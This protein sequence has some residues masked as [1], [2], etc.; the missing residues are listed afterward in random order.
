MGANAGLSEFC[1]DGNTTSLLSTRCS[2]SLVPKSK[3]NISTTPESI[4]V[5]QFVT[6]SK[7]R[8]KLKIF[9]SYD[10][11]F[12]ISFSNKI[13]WRRWI[14]VRIISPTVGLLV[15]KCTPIY[16]YPRFNLNFMKVMRT[17]SFKEILL[18]ASRT[19]SVLTFTIRGLG[20]AA[21]AAVKDYCSIFRCWTSSAVFIPPL[22]RAGLYFATAIYH[23]C[24]H[25]ASA[26]VRAFL[27]NFLARFFFETLTASAVSR[28]FLSR[29]ALWAR[30]FLRFLAVHSRV[31]SIF[32][33]RAR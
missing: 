8:G 20:R 15:L 7:Q 16:T 21:F 6:F 30:V 33:F 11:I 22:L 28:L 12:S 24:V 23:C 2:K 14:K 26:R 27:I 19:R 9:F 31:S 29:R 17:W 4:I 25:T 3:G 10:I 5:R 13:L 18:F 32:S 1:W